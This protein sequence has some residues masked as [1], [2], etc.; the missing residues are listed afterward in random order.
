MKTLGPAVVLALAASAFG[1]D[2]NGNSALCDRKYSNVTFIGAHNSPFVGVLP[3][4]NQLTDVTAQLDKGVR[5]LTAQTHDKDG[6]IELCH[7]D[8]DLLDV[9]TLQTYLAPI[10]TWL[11]GH[12]NEVV[13][14]LLTNGDAIDINKFADAFTAAGLDSYA[15][16]PG[17]DL[18]LDDWPTLGTFVANNKR[19]I[20]FMD[21]NSDTSKVNYILDEFKY[22]FETPF[23]PTDSEFPQ[24]DLDRPA[25][26]SPDGRMFIV[27]ANSMS[28]GANAPETNFGYDKLSP[29]RVVT[30]LAYHS[31]NLD[32]DLFG[33]LIPDLAEA[34]TTNSATSILA[35]SDICISKYSR[36]PN[37]VLVATAGGMI[38]T[39]TPVAAA[40]SAAEFDDSASVPAFLWGGPPYKQGTVSF[41]TVSYAQSTNSTT[42]TTLPSLFI[43][44]SR[45]VAFALNVPS[46]SETDLYFSLMLPKSVTWG[47]IGLGSSK[48]A[49]SLILVAYSSSSGKNVT[50][51]PRIASGHSEPVYTSDIEV[52]AL[53]GTGLSSD[54]RYIFN[55]RCSNCRS[56]NGGSIDVTSKSQSFLYATGPDGDIDSDALDAPLKMHL[57]Y[58][59]FKLDMVH[60][61][62]SVNAAPAIPISNT[63]DSV[64]TT[65]GLSVTGSR[66]IAAQAHAVIMVFCFVGLFPFGIFVLRLGN[67]VR[68][69]AVNQ[70]LALIGVVVGFGLGVHTSYFYNRSKKFN[71]AHQVIGILLFIFVLAQFVL[72]FMHHRI[73][74][75]TQQPTKLAPVHVWMGRVIIPVGVINAFL[76]FRF[77]Q[78]PQYNWVIAGLVI[79]I[80]PVM[81]LILFTK[82]FIQKRWKKTKAA[83]G[84]E[85]GGYDM[86]PWR[87]PEAQAGYGQNIT[88]TA[89][90]NNHPQHTAPI[91]V[92]GQPDMRSYPGYP[93]SGGGN[94]SGNLGPQQEVRE[95]V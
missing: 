81:A 51:S 82:K 87:Q 24:C 60:A 15:Y 85:Q 95:Y 11:D 36:D 62:S 4:Q 37:V 71:D 34:E 6:A 84:E 55:G 17:A 31:H 1:L 38:A 68:W 53:D 76:G 49:G 89:G 10:K 22:Y 54:T 48:M 33:V 32:F 28:Q 59:N 94:K 52:E 72:G 47:A 43:S 74:K 19:L 7:T 46:D 42:N 25:G 65:Q 16:V 35:Q 41:F 23:D 45:D 73:Y 83:P 20:V 92:M 78:S 39:P 29:I 58:G 80:F 64:A 2:C 27:K 5:Y 26:A 70:G 30:D 8:C 18:A 67:W 13:T 90:Q 12:A 75:K 44:P 69:H 61:T 9:G 56:W 93:G 66:D 50:L 86:E 88:V 57:N 79:F 63:T 77:A 40:S 21:Y 14:L 91:V 3:T